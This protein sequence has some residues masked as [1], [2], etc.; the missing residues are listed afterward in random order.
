MIA[1]IVRARFGNFGDCK[2]IKGGDG[3]CELRIDFGAGYRIYF[4]PYDSTAIV[5][6]LGGDKSSQARDIE[7][8]KKY[9]F[10]WIERNKT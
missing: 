5:A 10:D 6:L 9:W 2:Q 8:A 3:I 7:K 4:A 1:R